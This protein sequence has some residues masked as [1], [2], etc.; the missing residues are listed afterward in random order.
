M[1]L[2]YW[3]A[4]LSGSSSCLS[5]EVERIRGLSRLAPLLALPVILI[6]HIH[7]H[8]I[9]WHRSIL[10]H[11]AYPWAHYPASICTVYT[12]THKKH[13]PWCTDALKKKKLTFVSLLICLFIHSINK[14]LQWV[15]R[16]TEQYWNQMINKLALREITSHTNCQLF[17][18]RHLG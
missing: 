13:K 3:S 4:W 6:A 5:C 7:L 16:L 17:C 8:S 11:A 15:W 14:T 18:S 9:M 12:H 1:A 2:N 10:V